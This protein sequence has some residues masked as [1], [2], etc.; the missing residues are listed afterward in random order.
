MIADC[1]LPIAEW[2]VI[3][4]LAGAMLGCDRGSDANVA[5]AVPVKKLEEVR[6]NGVVRGRV[7]LEG[8]PPA[9]QTIENKPCHDGAAPLKEET[10]VVGE[11]RGLANA[12]VY[13]EGL[14]RVDGTSMPPAVLDQ[15]NCRYEPHVLG[16]TV[17][18]SLRVTSSAPTMH[19]VHYV[20]T[21]N[22]A[23]NLTMTRAGDEKTVTFR[24]GVEF[25]R[26][27]CDVHPWMAAWIGVFDNP[28]F[29]VTD[30]NGRFEIAGLPAGAYKLV[31]WHERYGRLE[32]EVKV[33]DT[34]A[35]ID[36]TYRQ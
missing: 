28:F 15:A 10:V 7:A 35:T 8:T 24:N 33:G 5:A 31:A 20:P 14:P 22:E 21:K 9:M 4:L 2:L 11:A 26:V 29:A 25:I 18:Q 12:F 16:V 1:R 27:R 23:R 3:V 13:V 19:N 30:A 6:G 32:N 17:G 34:P 36:V